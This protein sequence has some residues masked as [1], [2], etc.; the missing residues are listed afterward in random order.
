M[1][2]LFQ[3]HPLALFVLLVALVLV[4]LPLARGGTIAVRSWRARRELATQTAA[5]RAAGAALDV[6]TALAA[7]FVLSTEAEVRDLKDP[8]KPGSWNPA[9]DGPRYLARVVGDLR[10]LGGAS[11]AQLRALQGLTAVEASKLLASIAE[12]QVQKL[13]ATA[14]P[15][16]VVVPSKPLEVSLGGDEVALGRGTVAPPAPIEPFDPTR[17]QDVTSTARTVRQLASTDAAN[18]PNAPR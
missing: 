15:P 14:A 17:T 2:A 3:A 13:R 4:G 1:L 11:V 16:V 12:A 5:Q 10:D 7:T 8:L 18:D 9:T 6:L